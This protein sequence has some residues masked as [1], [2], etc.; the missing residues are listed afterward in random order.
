MK[1]VLIKR[2]GPPDVL[3]L[4]EIEKPAPKRGEVRVRVHASTV[5]AG[6]VRI[7]KGDPFFLRV[8]GGGIS[9]PAKV[10]TPGME[11]AGDVDAVGEGV[12]G[13]AIGEAVFGSAGLKF[14]ANAQYVCAPEVLL[15]AK[16]ADVPY[17]LAA[18]IAFGGISALH[19]LRA[20]GLQAGQK[21]L[22][23][24]ASGSVGTAAIQ[25]ARRFG[26]HVTGVCGHTNVELVR[27]L[28]ADAVLDYA[29]DDYSRDGAI[30]DVVFDTVGKSGI[31]RGVRALKRGGAYVF[32][33]TSLT[34][35]A[36]V[37]SFASLTGRVRVIGGI[38]R[39]R[40]ADLSFLM[41]LVTEGA[42][43]PA[44]DR[45]YPLGDIVAAHAYVEAGH[46]KGNVV[47]MVN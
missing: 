46:K 44:I 4:A 41:Q 25:L 12:S 32:A 19:Y 35:Y 20:A 18:P 34:S 5:C 17:E 31:L 23:Y 36:L 29:V 28:G 1:A 7:R 40:S 24:G 30:Y 39:G 13:F 42:F 10:R 45:T 37:S 26:A 38:A 15:A 16:P 33:A 6:D 11:L 27:S 9:R 47:I 8:V 2:Y 43:T 3:Q 22:V 14:G 21:L